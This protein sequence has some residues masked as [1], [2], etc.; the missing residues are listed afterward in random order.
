MTDAVRVHPEDR[1][2][3][4]ARTAQLVLDAIRRD[5]ESSDGAASTTQPGG[6]FTA[7]PADVARRHGVSADWVRANAAALGGVRI[8]TG[9]KPRHR[10]NLAITDNRIAAMHSDPEAHPPKPAE[11][12]PRRRRKVEQ[13]DVPLLPIKGQRKT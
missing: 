10:F 1:E 8:G 5:V 2:A 3:I 13:S 12:K 4:A 6:G 11:P 7:T 9:K